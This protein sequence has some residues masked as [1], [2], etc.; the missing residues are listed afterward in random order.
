VTSSDVVVAQLWR[1]PVK[2]MQGERLPAV[3]I[4]GDGVD[5]DR[6]WGVR[7]ERTGRVLTGRREARLLE[8]AARLAAGGEPVID[9]PDGTV[10]VGAGEATDTV[11]SDWLARPV[12]LV[13]AG[14]HGGRAEYFA[15]PTDDASE[16]I[17]WTMPPERFVD[18]M[19]LLVMTT[20]SLRA[21]AALHPAG[22]WDVRRFRPNVLLDAA[23]D[24]WLEDDWCGRVVR[25]G[26]VDVVPQQ[27]C[28]RCTM[29]T[30]PQPG[31]TRDLDIYRTLARHH[32]GN[33]GVWTAV[34][35][36]GTITENDVAHLVAD[37]LPDQG[38]GGSS[39]S[40][41]ARVDEDVEPFG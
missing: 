13:E 7:D 38:G 26:E 17:E 16:A 30:R 32:G 18:A 8:A 37:D 11:L 29:V 33:L 41:P 40:D 15:D 10:V 27:P 36:G 22:E 1:Y 25:I 19:P 12:R 14:V 2:S 20:A 28:I 3:E 9:L 34:R 35:D 24:G 5:G 39:G 4:H 6:R 23:G 31:L 21:G